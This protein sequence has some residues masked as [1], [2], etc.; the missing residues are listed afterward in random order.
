MNAK[1]STKIQQCRFLTPNAKDVLGKLLRRDPSV[2]LNDMDALKKHRFFKAVD[3]QKC[4]E[5]TW[6]VPPYEPQM[7]TEDDTSHFD[8]LFTDM[9]VVDTP[10]TF[11]PERL[12]SPATALAESSNEGDAGRLDSSTAKAIPQDGKE[13]EKMKDIFKGF[14]FVNDTLLSMM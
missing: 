6:R 14:S 4:L 7:T 9:P 1:V 5:K 10:V 11:S 2:R 12:R 13:L 8:K 3:W